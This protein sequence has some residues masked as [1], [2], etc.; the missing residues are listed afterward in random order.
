MQ[1]LIEMINLDEEEVILREA[2]ANNVMFLA[3]E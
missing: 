2:I 3:F 1:S